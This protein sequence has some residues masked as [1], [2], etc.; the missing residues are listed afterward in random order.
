MCILFD[1]EIV[2]AIV[3]NGIVWYCMPWSAMIFH[4][5][6][7]HSMLRY[8]VIYAY[9]SVVHRIPWF[10]LFGINRVEWFGKVYFVFSSMF[11]YSMVWCGT[12]WYGF[13][14][15]RMVYHTMLWIAGVVMCVALFPNAIS[16]NSIVQLHP[17]QY[18]WCVSRYV[19]LN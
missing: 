2:H 16:S 19:L 7:W 9:Y 3:L 12:F 6:S 15:C 1:R 18:Y 11:L 8:G 5:I 10:I 14:L 13:V 4:W 17:L